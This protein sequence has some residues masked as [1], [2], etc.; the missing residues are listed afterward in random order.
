MET[1]LIKKSIQVNAPKENVWDV[2]ISDE[3]NV[4]WYAAFSAGTRAETDWQID[5]KVSFVDDDRNGI[6][7][8]I[9]TNNP[10]ELLEIEYTGAIVNGVEETES[11]MAQGVMGFKEIYWLK[12]ANG[13]TQLDIQSDMGADYYDSMSEAWDKA[14]LIIK[15]MAEK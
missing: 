10:A 6:V 1:K 8:K 2:L 15:E 12:E 9:V 11:D 14:L 5:S 13:V 4:K 7:G 3:K